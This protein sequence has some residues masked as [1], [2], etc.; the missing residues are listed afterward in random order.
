MSGPTNNLGRQ[1]TSPSS[2]KNQQVSHPSYQNQQRKAV[3]N[4]Q[5]PDLRLNPPYSA[6]RLA[7][8]V[9]NRSSH[10]PNFQ[11]RMYAINNP[12]P[13]MYYYPTNNNMVYTAN[14]SSPRDL[15][16]SP[17]TLFA[18]LPLS[19]SATS[20]P[21]GLDMGIYLS[22]EADAMYAANAEYITSYKTT[23]SSQQQQAQQPQQPQQQ[24]QQQVVHAPAMA[25]S[26]PLSTSLSDLSSSSAGAL[27]ASQ[28]AFNATLSWISTSQQPPQMLSPTAAGTF[29]PQ[30]SASGPAVAMALTPVTASTPITTHSEYPSIPSSSDPSS[31]GDVSA[32]ESPYI[33]KE[34][35]QQQQ[36][37]QA[38][39]PEFSEFHYEQDAT[40]SSSESWIQQ[41]ASYED[42]NQN[43][44]F[45]PSAIISSPANIN[46]QRRQS[47]SVIS[48]VY[49]T[50]PQPSY[51]WYQPTEQ[52]QEQQQ[53][54]QQQ[55]QPHF[56]QMATT[57]TSEHSFCSNQS[58]HHDDEDTCHFTE[59]DESSSSPIPYMSYQ[60]Q[61]PSFQSTPNY[62]DSTTQQISAIQ[63]SSSS[64]A[65]DLQ[66]QQQ[67]QQQQL[68]KKYQ[69]QICGKFFRRDLPRHLRTH[70]E[71]ARFTCP[72]PR[73]RCPHKRGQF[74]RPYDFKKHLLHGHFT[75]DDQKRVR[76]FRNLR[77]KLS[78][79]GTCVCGQRFQANKWLEEHVLSTTN[80]CPL[81]MGLADDRFTLGSSS[82]SPMK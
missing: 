71:I 72:Y 15:S 25:L 49:S 48:N 42:P 37:L 77:S 63:S 64:S 53:Q 67:T 8:P 9:Y 38:Q 18:P 23:S 32:P 54:Q 7:L 50:M 10:N 57:S 35:Q 24:Q 11:Q 66:P 58:H 69:C 55:E 36:Q 21:V 27:D 41:A 70:Q 45:D 59:S 65:T 73:D 40:F 51:E 3:T 80:R 79:Y 12:S 4:Q 60:A 78:Y 31:V 76:S 22:S 34:Q 14:R 17:S 81:L 39:Q 82:I 61:S 20:S 19:S 30:A 46:T 56:Q 74:N 52:D 1:T 2:P 62:G 75:F 68:E 43:I 6:H 5:V 44:L 16:L 26:S 33:L 13:Q 28:A 47:D 29:Q